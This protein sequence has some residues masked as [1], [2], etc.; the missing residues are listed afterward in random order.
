M[1]LL[2]VLFF[3]LW[4]TVGQ[5]WADQ[6]TAEKAR[7]QAQTF[8]NS[9]IASGNGPR[10]AP[11]VTPQ[12][13][14]EK[15]V[16][17]LYVFNVSNDGGFIIVSNDD[18]ALPIL[19]YSDS[20][21]LDPDHMPD[22]MRAWLQGYAD[23]IAWAKE[24]HFVSV[25]GPTAHHTAHINK[26]PKVAIAPLL[27]TTWNQ[28]TPYNDLCP[29]YTS[30]EKSVTG[31]VATA[32][33]Q[34]MKYNRY[35]NMTAG[36]PAYD[37]DYNDTPCVPVGA[38][39]AT[40]FRWD[41]MI[42]DYRI[43]N[44]TPNYTDEQASAVAEL[45][46]YCGSSV[47]MNYGESSAANTAEVATAL[48]NYFGY[49]ETTSYEDRSF[50]SYANWINLL[51]NELNQGRAMV[52]SG[53]SNGG[54]HAFVCDG[55]D[56]ED[57]FHIN[58]GWDGMSDSYF[59]LSALDP[60]AQG[61]GGSSSTDGFNY[62]QGAVVGIQKPSDNGTVLDVSTQNYSLALNSVSLSQSTVSLG[63][64]VDVT[65][66]IT[67]NGTDQYDGDL[68]IYIE[69]MG[70]I[71]GKTFVIDAGETKDC[72]IPYTPS[73]FTGNCTIDCMVP[74]GN[75]NY[76]YLD[77]DIYAEL[78][79]SGTQIETTD[80][81]ELTV[82]GWNVENLEISGYNFY[83]YGSTL[84]GTITVK[85]P[86]TDKNYSSYYEWAIRK[87]GDFGL[88]TYTSSLITI[89]AGES[90]TIPIEVNNLK[91]DEKYFL[92]VTYIKNGDWT[93]WASYGPFTVK[94]GIITYTADGTREVN[95]STT[96]YTVPA[97]ALVVDVTGTGVTSITPNT[98]PNTLYI[99]S[100]TTPPD[101][102]TNSNVVKNNNGT[103]TAENISLQDGNGFF[104]PVDFTAGNIEFKYSFTTGA[105]GN[106]G[107]NT[108][109]LPFDV[110]NVT[111]DGT[112]I[113][114]FHSASDTGKNFW[115]KQFAGDGA[116]SVS[117]DFVDGNTLQANTPYIV[118]FP[119]N[120]W[121]D[122][123][124][125]SSKQIIFKG[126]NAVVHKSSSISSVTGDNYRFIGSTVQDN[127]ANIY[128]INADGNKFELTNGSAP[129]R[130]FFK[131]GIFDRTVTS[132]SIGGDTATAINDL[133]NNLNV[134][135]NYYDLQ[136]R[137]V[138]QPQKGLYIV[139]GKKVIVK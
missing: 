79:V 22:N 118:A 139:N 31:C 49:S 101:G 75:G 32:M 120:H 134:N 65:F 40:T 76:Y 83:V 88:L 98:Q 57:Y 80:D 116:T 130:A 63:E 64:T 47:K 8:L 2:L 15:Q 7:Q 39:E 58:W 67:N 111:A 86:E 60:D 97:N 37:K 119:G 26:A 126:V 28:G 81:V 71:T 114:W 10:H 132:L 50:Y 107:W 19:G 135:N 138:M 128:C 109:M 9:R 115:V 121:G 113:D 56:T 1:T 129:F 110:T 94:P 45:M 99:Y 137:R 78:T 103:Y 46:H 53:Q 69:G 21:T 13:M 122:N 3:P 73:G 127:T 42:D 136:G 90:I 131:P 38:L 59:K 92:L 55:Y 14:Q 124:D 18:C 82:T 33:A 133:N 41:D 62:G 44:N 117:F 74:I 54:G 35:A 43:T 93:D 11:G 51:Y 25:D 23:E 48:K 24:H 61:I 104:S 89:P 91:Y 5:L 125:L 85:N 102:L 106:N 29:E 68:W 72:V 20:G 87:D 27:T 100:G 36:L 84:K 17:G 105:D 4:G 123:W 52:Y 6:V 30:G 112:G 70:L 12:L 96:T 34:V 77:Y 16:S 108:I 66:N 95:K